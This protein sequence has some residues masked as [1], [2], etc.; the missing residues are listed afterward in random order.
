MA[1]VVIAV[2]SWHC[3]EKPFRG[4]SGAITRKTLLL[5]ACGAVFVSAAFG[6]F[7]YTKDGMPQR[8]PIQVQ[9]MLERY[10]P[11][12]LFHRVCYETLT[13]IVEGNICKIGKNTANTRSFLLWGDSHATIL[14]YAIDPLAKKHGVAGG[15]VNYPGCP[16]LL[17]ITQFESTSTI[18][19][20][21]ANDAVM[22]LLIR[23]HIK[24]VILHARWALAVTGTRYP[25]ERGKS[26]IF[27]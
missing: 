27:S 12:V 9:T 15:L 11:N 21:E 10:D 2:G 22:A 19:C 24:T 23:T 17:G 8:F 13:D 7:V 6:A 14:A 1:S 25:N 20:E 16:P 4:R 5:S 18:Q 3:V 26:A